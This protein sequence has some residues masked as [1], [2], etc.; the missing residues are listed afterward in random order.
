MVAFF[1]PRRKGALAPTAETVAATSVLRQTR[2][3]WPRRA[4]LGLIGAAA[5]AACD[6]G[7]MVAT[8]A[9]RVDV[10]APVQVAL[11]LPSGGGDAG[12]EVIA[13]SLENAA[14]LAIADLDGVEIDLRIYSDGGDPGRAATVAAQAAADGVQILLGPV[15]AGGATAAGQAV[16]SRGISVLSFSNNPDAAGGNVF[17]LGQT[18]ANTAD[19]LM[20]HAVSQGVGRTLIVHERNPAGDAGQA[21]IAAAVARAGGAVAGVRGF[22]FSQQGVVEALPTI[23]EG[24]AEGGA[25]SIFFTSNTAGALPLLTQLLA[26][27]RAG[28]TE[29]QYLGLTRWD[30]PAESLELRSIQGG[31]F[32]L[33]DPDLQA[34]FT[35]RYRAAHGGQA[36]HPLAWLAYDGIAAIGALV[37]SGNPNALSR[38]ALTQPQGFAG[39]GGVFRLRPD[40]TNERGLAIATIRDSRVQV[41]AP[42]PRSFTGAGS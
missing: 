34:Q 36:P 4:V 30:I 29:Y 13:R 27:N 10:R 9:P 40:G 6:G 17:I 3:G 42:A 16:A 8:S 28:P 2:P 31:W 23:T 33:P 39:V 41:V 24:A 25:Q 12:S 19:R 38:E 22:D 21:A 26:E 14:R 1:T 20:R 37:A 32:A 7:G 18:F 35:A 15:F 5:L 11:I